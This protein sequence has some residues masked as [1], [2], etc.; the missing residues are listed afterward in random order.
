M[1]ISDNVILMILERG[2]LTSS[3]MAHIL[4]ISNLE[5]KA[6]LQKHPQV[7]ELHVGGERL[8]RLL[9]TQEFILND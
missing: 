7:E 6:L 9:P 4:G 1:E 2:S 5:A 3:T 8:F